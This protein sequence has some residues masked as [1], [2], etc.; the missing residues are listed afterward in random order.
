KPDA[1]RG[2]RRVAGSGRRPCGRGDGR[3]A[4]RHGSW[5]RGGSR[6]PGT[7][8]PTYS[9]QLWTGCR[10]ARVAGSG[11]LSNLM[12]TRAIISYDG[13]DN[14]HDA[15][16]LGRVFVRAGTDTCLAYVLHPAPD[17]DTA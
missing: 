12:A 13:T 3:G 14:D 16:A 11:M 9:R 8:G 6:A 1:A 4:R 2:G 17:E 15:V 7:L 5:L 10:D